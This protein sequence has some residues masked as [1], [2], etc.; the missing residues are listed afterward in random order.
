MPYKLERLKPIFLLI[1][2]VTFFSISFFVK[3]SLFSLIVSNKEEVSVGDYSTNTRDYKYKIHWND[4]GN[5]DRRPNQITFDLYNVLDENTIIQSKT[6]NKEDITS[7]IT[8]IF[9]DV[10]Y[11]NPDNTSANYIVK[12]NI[13]DDYLLN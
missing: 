6:I 9:E 13:P 10:P 3:K 12:N 2:L 11:S 5:E 4:Y 7:S 1:I 8:L